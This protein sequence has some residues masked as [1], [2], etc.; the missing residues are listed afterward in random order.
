MSSR[1]SYAQL[2]T[3]QQEAIDADCLARVKKGIAL[4][5]Q[6]HGPNW[7][8]HIDLNTL[9]LASGFRCVLGQVYGTFGDGITQLWGTDPEH[10]PSKDEVAEHGFYEHTVSYEDTDRYKPLDAAW[11]HA[12]TPHVTCA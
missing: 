9:D 11:K 4:L 7:A 6:Q 3:P 8:D 1:P 5:E 2:R 12:L 10:W